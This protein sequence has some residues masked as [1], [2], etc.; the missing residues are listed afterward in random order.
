[1]IPTRPVNRAGFSN[2]SASY[3]VM[4][5]DLIPKKEPFMEKV[6]EKFRFHGRKTLSFVEYRR[7]AL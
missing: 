6:F 4:F 2:P 3:T 1:M 7:H 5:F